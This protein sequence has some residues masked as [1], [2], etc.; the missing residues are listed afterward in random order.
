MM[1]WVDVLIAFV[2][3]FVVSGLVIGGIELLTKGTG[4]EDRDE[5]Y[6]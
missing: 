5:L 3:F 1:Y 2:G 4:L 6:M